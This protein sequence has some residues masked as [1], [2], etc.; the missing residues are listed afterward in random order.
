MSPDI[1]N[2]KH[3]NADVEKSGIWRPLNFF[4][5]GFYFE[6]SKCATAILRYARNNV[7]GS[8]GEMN[9]ETF[10]ETFIAQARRSRKMRKY[11]RTIDDHFLD[12]DTILKNIA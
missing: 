2:W 10:K 4:D 5:D 1:F 3:T 12:N 8:A 6:W 9:W 11:R 7:I